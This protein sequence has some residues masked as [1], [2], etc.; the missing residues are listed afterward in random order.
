VVKFTANKN[1]AECCLEIRLIYPAI[2]RHASQN[3]T[4]LGVQSSCKCLLLG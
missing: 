2:G 1:A 4:C 3:R